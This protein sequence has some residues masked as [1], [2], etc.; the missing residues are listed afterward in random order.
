MSVIDAAM[1]HAAAARAELAGGQ[2]R[3]SADAVL[4]QIASVPWRGV[5]AR[6][7]DHDLAALVVLVRRAAADLDGFA[8]TVRS[9]LAGDAMSA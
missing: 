7:F 9:A 6:A 5:A 3:C 2:L 4:K 8:D 1:G